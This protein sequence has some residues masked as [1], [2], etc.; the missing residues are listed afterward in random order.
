MIY[1]RPNPSQSVHEVSDGSIRH[2]ILRISKKNKA[3]ASSVRVRS[4]GSVKSYWR[5]IPSL[6][7][8]QQKIY[9][10]SPCLQRIFFFSIPIYFLQCLPL[11]FAQSLL[12][13]L[14]LLKFLQLLT[15]TSTFFLDFLFFK[16]LI[17][18]KM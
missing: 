13:F 12:K 14:L 17:L 16:V 10:F 15:K 2:K 1:W 8:G 9:A 6:T 5:I 18:N 3:V 11:S 7:V 4:L